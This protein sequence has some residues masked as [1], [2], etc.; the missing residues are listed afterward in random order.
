MNV[1]NNVFYYLGR[2]VFAAV[3]HISL[4]VPLGQCFGLL[5]VN[6]AGK[7][8]TFKML[9]GDLMPDSGTAYVDS[10]DIATDLNQVLYV[11]LWPVNPS[12]CRTKKQ[13]YQRSNTAKR[14]SIRLL[15]SSLLFKVKPASTMA[16]TIP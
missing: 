5:G 2:P 13:R 6:G 1:F 10:F 12:L 3:D 15:A 8:T 7:T 11:F 4:G 9:T 16:S 14:I